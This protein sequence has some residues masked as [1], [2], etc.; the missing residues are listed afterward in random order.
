MNSEEEQLISSTFDDVLFELITNKF[1]QE[2]N[3]CLAQLSRE[4]VRDAAENG[5][6]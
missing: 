5:E 2:F 1:K 3:A 4:L 6:L